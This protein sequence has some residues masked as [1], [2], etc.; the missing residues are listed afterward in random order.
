MAAHDALA[1]PAS[2]LSLRV[3]RSAAKQPLG[4]AVLRANQP[5]QPRAG[6]ARQCT[7]LAADCAL[8]GGALDSGRDAAPGSADYLANQALDRESLP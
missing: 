2:R 3:P 7:C 1:A 8:L 4:A 6:Q 5:A